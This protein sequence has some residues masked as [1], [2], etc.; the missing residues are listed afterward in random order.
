VGAFLDPVGQGDVMGM[1]MPV[2]IA[3]IP[4]IVGEE[5][6]M[7]AVSLTTVGQT[8]FQLAGPTLAGFLIS[9]YGFSLVDSVG[10]QWAVGSM[11][12]FLSAVSIGFYIFFPKLRKLE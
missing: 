3:I 12:I 11:A 1:M 9:N 6:V 7:N 5:R 8:V 2:R 10:V 4:E